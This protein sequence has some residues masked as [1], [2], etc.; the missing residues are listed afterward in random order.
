MGEQAER[1][2]KPVSDSAIPTDVDNQEYGYDLF[3]YA[4]CDECRN[5]VNVEL[6]G[7]DDGTGWHV[8]SCPCEST[9][10]DYRLAPWPRAGMEYNGDEWAWP[11]EDSTMQSTDQTA[12]TDESE[13]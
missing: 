6:Y 1:D 2:P 4:W 3:I 12:L 5:F 8:D 13:N 10:V 7:I 9:H 11:D